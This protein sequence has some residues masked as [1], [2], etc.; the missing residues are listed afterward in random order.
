[1]RLSLHTTVGYAPGTIT[2]VF[3]L[4]CV[5][6]FSGLLLHAGDL[7][8]CEQSDASYPVSGQVQFAVINAA[9]TAPV[10]N[11]FVV[12]G[13]CSQVLQNLASG[14]FLISEPLNP[15]VV[16]MSIRAVL[17]GIEVDSPRL[18][19]TNLHKGT[20]EVTIS[21]GVTAIVTF[22]NASV[23]DYYRFRAVSVPGLDDT[24]ATAISDDGNISGYGTG[25]T[26]QTGFFDRSGRKTL[27]YVPGSTGTRASGVNDQ[28]SVVGTYSD[29]TGTHGF[30]YTSGIYTTIDAPAPALPNTTSLVAVNN[31]GQIAGNSLAS[32][33]ILN[34]KADGFILSSSMF[35]FVASPGN[36]FTINNINNLGQYVGSFGGV[37][38]FSASFSSRYTTH[39]PITDTLDAI[40]DSGQM[41]L[42]K[43]YVIASPTTTLGAP[44]QFPYAVSTQ[45][46]GL[47]DAGDI[48]GSYDDASGRSHAFVGQAS[49]SE[50]E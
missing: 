9:T 23:P 32:D 42:N 30:E 28:G 6:I 45:I 16:T 15:G 25:S 34:S 31:S 47:N 39:F 36:F 27:V 21:A 38:L 4:L 26:G 29:A 40:N 22:T 14:G 13:A 18:L 5:G 12:A 46:L 41:I 37:L 8:I 20:A 7:Q 19:R 50:A 48:A 11:L 35:G 3:I 44:V 2:K 10:E 33:V 43:S 17:N 49:K 24:V 1:M